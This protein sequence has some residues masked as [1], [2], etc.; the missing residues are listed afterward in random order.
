MIARL[1]R[2]P[3]SLAVAASL[4]LHGAA[5][6]GALLILGD[7]P[8]EPIRAQTVAMV[9]I[10]QAE[11]PSPEAA[12]ARTAPQ[13]KPVLTPPPA[14]RPAIPPARPMQAAALTPSPKPVTPVPRAEPLHRTPPDFPA[15]PRRPNPTPTA[16]DAPA[17]PV[18]A[19]TSETLSET[20]PDAATARDGAPAP[21]QSAALME[22]PP[23]YGKPGLAN[24]RPRYPWLSRQRGEQ[25]RVVL[26]VTVDDMGRA[27]H[28]SVLAGSGFGRL[29]RAAIEAL[30]KWR[31]EPATRA[32]QAVAGAVDVPVTF[33]L[34]DN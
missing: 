6:A 23:G 27:A 31:F 5:L 30:E 17:A 3:L 2:H 7:K 28:V 25:G 1:R 33:R 24:P 10:E 21:Q 8:P 9:M 16:Q 26:R 29:D 14:Q 20:S 15:P 22:T 32:G 18:P 4:L 12:P 34:G 11:P 19:P 13:P